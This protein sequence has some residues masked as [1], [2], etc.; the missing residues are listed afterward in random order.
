MPFVPDQQQTAGRFVPDAP[1]AVQAGR[2]LMEVP[3]QAGLA[4]R[5]L[6]EGPAQLADLFTEPLRNL[7]LNPILGALGAP[8]IGG[9]TFDAVSRGADAVGLPKPENANE[10]VV[11]DASRLLAGGAIPIGAA[12][13]AGQAAGPLVRALAESPGRQAASFVGSGLAGGSVR[14][15]GGGPGAQFVASLAGGLA[16]P[17]AV[18]QLAGPVEASMQWMRRMLSP[19]NVE[20]ALKTELK[21]AGVDWDALGRA[22]Q[23]QLAKDAQSALYTGQ[24]INS[25]ALRRL[26][27]FRNIGA[28]PTLGSVSM[29]PGLV[30][31]ERNLAKQM[32]NTSAPISGAPSL[33]QIENANT[34]RVIQTLDGL[35]APGVTA[36]STAD[37]FGAHVG[38]LDRTRKA[39]VD[40]AYTDARAAAGR[41]IPL[42][43]HGFVQE[44]FD[45]LAQSNRGPW[46]PPQVRQVLNTLSAG[47]GQFTVNTIDQLKTLLAQELR[48]AQRAEDGATVAAIADVRNALENVNVAPQARPYGST[49]P[50]TGADGARLA[51]ADAQGQ[52]LSQ[53]ALGA[54][55]RARSLAR[56]RF[57]WQRSAPFI[58]DALDG[59]P[60]EQF[61]RRHILTAKPEDLE[62]M[63]RTI[64]RDG[65]LRDTVRGHF[66]E[67]IKSRGAADGDVTRIGSSKGMEDAL[68]AIGDARLRKFFDP[69]EISLI[70]SAVKVARYI[71]AQPAGS[72]VNNS[73]SAAMVWGRLSDLLLKGANAPMVGPLV[74]QPLRGATL[75]IQGR[76]AMQAADALVAARARQRMPA[77]P[78]LLAAGIPRGEQ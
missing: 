55:D 30:T 72:A 62:T 11:G 59:I 9:S 66:I 51:A 33:P 23:Q 5:Y 18:G 56:E 32:A 10:R 74:F 14:E 40:A 20:D 63:A 53:E 16:A 49:A 68:A 64:S 28:T 25:D 27:A 43:R 52:A 3:R 75:N 4:A 60:A 2:G 69:Q 48:K 45:N 78:L 6:A 12:A 70:K 34:Q 31:L 19:T 67:F 71:Q 35:G 41:D 1:L 22:T 77:T 42:D 38:A 13:K 76:Q 8:K 15:A 50:I 39:A 29:D 58:E 73:N 26:A 36:Q 61:V 44:A 24:P 47:E 65:S 7:V 46:L 17:M 54:F 37:A 21:R 57:E